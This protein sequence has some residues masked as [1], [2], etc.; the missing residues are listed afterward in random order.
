MVLKFDDGEQFDTSG[1]IR[2]EKHKDG[3]YVI[4][5]GM[6]VPCVDEEDADQLVSMLTKAEPK[7]GEAN[8]AEN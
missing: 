2:K 6:F 1:E 4:G 3:W 5:G 7:R 8:D